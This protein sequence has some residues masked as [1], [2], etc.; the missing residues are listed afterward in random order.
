MP[1]YC[2]SHTQ[3]SLVLAPIQQGY[4]VRGFS[5]TTCVQV[6]SNLTSCLTLGASSSGQSA[7]RVTRATLVQAYTPLLV[8]LPAVAS[9]PLLAGALVVCV[10]KHEVHT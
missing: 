3:H 10:L 2:L 9:Q 6:W 5:V 4:S 7:Q 8:F 1:A